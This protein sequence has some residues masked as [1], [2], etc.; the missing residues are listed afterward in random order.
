LGHSVELVEKRHDR[1]SELTAGRAPIFERGVEEIL[2]PA[3]ADGRI[4]ITSTP[5][6]T[7]HRI[8]LV[9]VGTPIADDGSSDV[10][11]L[12]AA[13]ESIRHELDSGAALVIRSTTQIGETRRLIDR[14]ALPESQVFVNPEF[15]RQGTALKDFLAP[16][17]LVLGWAGKGDPSLLDEVSDLTVALDAPRLRVTYEEAEM[18]KNSANAFLALKLSF[19]NEIAVLS[20]RY[21][22]DV[23]RV[24]EGIGYDPRIGSLYLRPSFGFG[25]SCLPKELQTIT[26]A[27]WERGITMHVTAAATAANSGTQQHFAQ[28][29]LDTLDPG[30]NN[31]VALLGL[32]F[33]ADTDDVRESPAIR[34]AEMLVNAGVQVRGYDPQAMTNTM[35]VAPWIETVPSIEAAVRGAHV[36]AITTEWPEFRSADWARIRNLVARPVIVDGRRLLDPRIMSTLGFQYLAV[37]SGASRDDS[38]PYAASS[39]A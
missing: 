30:H 37:G 22:A 29:I 31:R 15:L 38:V 12:T 13:I 8:I 20:E 34:V 9:C 26:L 4:V 10:T 23:D 14:L 5:T 6:P 18:I 11:Q 25:G 39:S 21:G 17:R 32:A 24:L 33:K 28:R 3:L 16:T 1:R 36:T 27:G 7:A 19:T 2:G 35:A